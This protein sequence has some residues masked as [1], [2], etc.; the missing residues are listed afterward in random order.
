MID[1]AVAA[2]ADYA[3]RTGLIEE[4]DRVWAVNRLLDALASMGPGMVVITS[5]LNAD[6]EVGNVAL[7]VGRG[8]SCCTFRRPYPGS[9]HG[10]GDLFTAALSALLIRGAPLGEAME[11][12]AFLVGE[13]IRR[14]GE[15]KKES[16]WGLDF[17]GALPAYIRRVEEMFGA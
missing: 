2:L 4:T 15:R 10:A 8:E 17:E 11:L 16:R 6:G 3:V 9:Y 5:V 1:N 12:A 14:T 13:S 7:D